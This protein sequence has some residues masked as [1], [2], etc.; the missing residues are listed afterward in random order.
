MNAAPFDSPDKIL[1]MS[2]RPEL[3]ID[4]EYCPICQ[5]ERTVIMRGDSEIIS[6]PSG[7]FEGKGSG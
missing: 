2:D 1:S 7:S 6:D 4:E 5:G 3:G